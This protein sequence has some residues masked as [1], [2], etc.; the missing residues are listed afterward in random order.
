MAL[1]SLVDRAQIFPRDAYR[2]TFER[3]VEKMPPA[4]CQIMVDLSLA[5]ERACEAELADLAADLDAGRLPDLRGSVT[6]LA[7]SRQSADVTRSPR[8]PPTTTCSRE[9][10]HE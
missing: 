3:L 4:A 8:L 2:R 7:P 6:L 1:I 10:A 9:K 5:H